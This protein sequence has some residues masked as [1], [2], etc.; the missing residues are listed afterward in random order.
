MFDSELP[1]VLPLEQKVGI[2]NQRGS[3]LKWRGTSCLSGFPYA[4]KELCVEF[5]E[6]VKDR[7][8][9]QVSLHSSFKPPTVTN[10]RS[11][12]GSSVGLTSSQIVNGR[13]RRE[14]QSKEMWVGLTVV[15]SEA[16][17]MEPW[18]REQGTWQGRKGISLEHSGRRTALSIHSC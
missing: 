3:F 17:R 13:G 6:S 2:Q 14:G 4:V 12:P 16:G 7:Y 18:G 15:G 11:L 9:S 10:T 8:L 5:S 1:P